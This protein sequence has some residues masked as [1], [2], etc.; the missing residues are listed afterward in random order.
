M[1]LLT[2][3]PHLKY[4]ASQYLSLMA[5]FL[6]L[7]LYKVV[8]QHMQGKVGFVIMNLLQIYQ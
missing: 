7:M 8:W 1:W 4:V 5:Y 3:Q 6:T 2:T